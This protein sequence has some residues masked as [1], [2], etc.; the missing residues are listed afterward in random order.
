MTIRAVLFDLDDTLFAH[1]AAV[2]AGVVAHL[3]A[4]GHIVA[5]PA[6]TAATWHDLEEHH[7]TRYLRGEVDFLEQRRHRARD[8]MRRFG[9]ELADADADAWF[10]AYLGSYR[11]GWTLH[12]D[13]LRCLDELAR[14][15]PG[16]R[17]GIVTNGELE[18]Q[19]SKLDAV[20]LSE[21]MQTVIASGDVG[22][23]KPDAAIFT[24][25]CERLG[26]RPDEAAMIGDR[27]RTDAIGAARAGLTGVWL[28]RH[29]SRPVDGDAAE[30][31]EAGIP[32][33]GSLDELP[34]LLASTR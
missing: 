21:R 25:A 20:V 2:D 16:V 5:D 23:R 7:Y 4:N 18:F 8:L 22:V 9:A 10:T 31:A 15:I 13:T 19:T 11:A 17:F 33:I 28:D 26:V 27:L 24:R 14:R 3:Q 34:D 12:E 29:G 32:R 1:R 6:A 30:A